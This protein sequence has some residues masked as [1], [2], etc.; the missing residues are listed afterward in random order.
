MN[1][2]ASHRLRRALSRPARAELLRRIGDG[3]TQRRM[4]L[5]FRVSRVTAE[6]LAHDGL[7]APEVATRIEGLLLGGTES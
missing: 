2:G 3:L 1:P 4:V 5:D 6:E 7:F